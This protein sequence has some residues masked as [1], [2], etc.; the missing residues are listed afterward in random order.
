MTTIRECQ[1]RPS[2][3][4]FTAAFLHGTSSWEPIESFNGSEHIVATFWERTN[5]NGRDIDDLTLFQAGETF[6]PLGP[7]REQSQVTSIRN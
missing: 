4:I 5:T 3:H 7:P 1:G 2:F 6:L